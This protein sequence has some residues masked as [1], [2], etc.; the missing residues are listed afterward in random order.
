MQKPDVERLVSGH[1]AQS[2]SEY[3]VIIGVGTS[4]ADAT[5]VFAGAVAGVPAY[6]AVVDDVAI[7]GVEEVGDVVSAGGTGEDDVS[8]LV[9]NVIVS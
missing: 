1:P 4:D 6:S 8:P 5:V 9:D 3:A 2:A 7:D